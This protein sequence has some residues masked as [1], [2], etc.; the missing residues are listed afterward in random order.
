[1]GWGTL[2]L[3]CWGEGMLVDAFGEREGGELGVGEGTYWLR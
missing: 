3:H 1:M 2:H